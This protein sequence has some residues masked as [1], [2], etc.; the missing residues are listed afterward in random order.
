MKGWRF[1]DKEPTGGP[2]SSLALVPIPT[3]SQDHPST[4]WGTHKAEGKAQMGGTVWPTLPLTPVGLQ[5]PYSGNV[6]GAWKRSVE[7]R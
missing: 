2:T 6:L 1:T 7:N 5:I 3:A 4:D